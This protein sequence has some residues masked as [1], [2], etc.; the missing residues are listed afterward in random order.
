MMLLIKTLRTA[1]LAEL[2][3]FSTLA[4]LKTDLDSHFFSARM[5]P[6]KYLDNT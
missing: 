4:A 2:M 3:R 1:S 6:L 5:R